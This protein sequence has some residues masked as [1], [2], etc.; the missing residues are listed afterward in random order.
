MN[1]E[2]EKNF[3]EKK[4]KV[5]SEKRVMNCVLEKENKKRA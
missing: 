3:R 4:K 1:S 5:K 2:R